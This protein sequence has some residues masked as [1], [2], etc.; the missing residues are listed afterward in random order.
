[1]T[2]TPTA[3]LAT[4]LSSAETL[5]HEI[6]SAKAYPLEFI[7]YRITGYRP[8]ETSVDLLT[9]IALE[10]DLGL[11]IEVLSDKLNLQVEGSSEAVLTIDDVTR[12]FNVASKTI[13]RWRRRGLP[14]R[15]F[16]FGD[17]KRRVGFLLSSVERFLQRRSD[18][19][20]SATNLSLID[21]PELS[22]IVRHAHRL[23]AAGCTVSQLSR[24]IARRLGR[25]PLGIEHTLRKHDANLLNGAAAELAAERTH[26]I[27]AVAE[28]L[29]PSQ[30]AKRFGLTRQSV[31]WLLLDA[32][33]ARL[34]ERKIKF[35][36]DELYHGS[37]AALA[38][39]TVANQAML[40]T[41][42]A[43]IDTRVPRDLPPYIRE[44]YRTPLLSAAQERALFLEFNYHKFLFVTALGKLDP[45]LPRWRQLIAMEHHLA[46]ATQVKN[47]IVHANLRLVVS[48]ARKHL[49]PSLN[50]MDLIS[51]GNLSLMRAVESFDTHRGFRLSTY[52]T[53]AIMKGLA[54]SVPQMQSQSTRLA[55]SDRMGELADANQPDRLRQFLHRDHVGQL[56]SRLDDRSRD[57][58][59]SHFGLRAGSEPQ[60]YDELA[61]RFGLTKSRIR[62][63]EADAL[64]SLRTDDQG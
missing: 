40:E 38:V 42:S 52:A 55:A 33:V 46:D 58:I 41:S 11:L 54:R 36:N 60:G 34:T 63:I 29:T 45:Q 3:K 30:L 48:V 43:S 16:T 31:Y 9:G 27:L 24:R 18:Q 6:D 47:K 64:A 20:E 35:V 26:E 28:A 13:Q 23:I 53:L 17:G 4:E 5:L 7:V 39:S 12:K 8:K 44:L 51:D 50:L 21:S 10:H 57:I 59:T 19:L 1:M 15:R 22:T 61:L 56:L 62:Q 37:D 14:A 49:R 25:S 32:K 2:F